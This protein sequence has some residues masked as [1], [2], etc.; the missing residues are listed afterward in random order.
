MPDCGTI[1]INRK[2]RVNFLI[3]KKQSAFIFI[4]QNYPCKRASYSKNAYICNKESLPRARFRTYLTHFALSRDETWKISYRKMDK[5]IWRSPF[6]YVT[7]QATSLAHKHNHQ[8]WVY[9]ILFC[10]FLQVFPGTRFGDRA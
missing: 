7:R 3:E 4:K 10:R 2:N 9:C 6:V 8:A 1:N 5:G